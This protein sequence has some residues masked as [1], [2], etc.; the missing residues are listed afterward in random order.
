[1][2]SKDPILVPLVTI[3]HHQLLEKEKWERMIGKVTLRRPEGG[4]KTQ[5]PNTQH[6]DMHLVH[7]LWGPFS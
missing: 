2:Q 6:A 1:M 5:T 4:V 7:R 3:G